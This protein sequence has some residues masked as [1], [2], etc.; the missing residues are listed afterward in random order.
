MHTDN[1]NEVTKCQL[2]RILQQVCISNE[3]ITH[4]KYIIITIIIS[5]GI[6]LYRAKTLGNICR[7]AYSMATT[8]FF[9]RQQYT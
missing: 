8:D 2:K 6:V 3:T 7:K 5:Q 1:H 9:N 4:E